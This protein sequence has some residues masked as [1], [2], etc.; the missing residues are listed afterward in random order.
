MSSLSISDLEIVSVT[1]AA[2]EI[3]ST[4]L[5]EARTALARV[6][7]AFLIERGLTVRD[8]SILDGFIFL[9]DNAFSRNWEENDWWDQ[10]EILKELRF[11]K[12]YR[13]RAIALLQ[14]SALHDH[15]TFSIGKIPDQDN[16]M[17]QY[18]SRRERLFLK[19]GYENVIDAVSQAAGF[20][21]KYVDTYPA[22]LL[23]LYAHDGTEEIVMVDNGFG[24]RFH[25][26]SRRFASWRLLYKIYK[27][28]MNHGVYY[29]GGMHLGLK[30]TYGRLHCFGSGAVVVQAPFRD[31]YAE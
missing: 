23:L 12:L 6:L 9:F 1:G 10:R 8:I 29:I 18:A 19:E 17:E 28:I 11:N 31:I 27:L 25:K 7:D 30:V 5:A 2:T 16:Q 14:K 24:A 13:E 21:R 22:L 15:F 26:P 20:Q 4:G 3:D